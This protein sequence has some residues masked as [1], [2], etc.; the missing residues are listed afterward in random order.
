[1]GHVD[2]N[3]L[4]P[5]LVAIVEIPKFRVEPAGEGAVGEP[6]FVDHGSSCCQLLFHNF[7]AMTEYFSC[8]G[9]WFGKVAAKYVL[10]RDL[11]EAVVKAI[12]CNHSP[13]QCNLRSAACLCS[14]KSCAPSGR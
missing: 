3:H 7:K 10:G 12:Q 11:R 4:L 5:F 13:I 8:K 9:S 14:G 6:K 2:Q 1:M